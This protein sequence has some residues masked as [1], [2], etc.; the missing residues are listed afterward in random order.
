MS[1]SKRPG[2]AAITR[3]PP[4][5]P[6]L[7]CAASDIDHPINTE[8]VSKAFSGDAGA[9]AEIA[10]WKRETGDTQVRAIKIALEAD[11]LVSSNMRD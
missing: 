6:Q 7:C 3:S 10:M 11:F 2:L 9:Q 8:L 1:I 4:V 5:M